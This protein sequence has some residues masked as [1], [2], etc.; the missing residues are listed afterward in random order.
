MAANGESALVP[1]IRFRPRFSLRTVFV[2]F[3]VIAGVL[4]VAN[5]YVR[6]RIERR[7]A[8]GRVFGSGGM[9]W[10][11]NPAEEIGADNPYTTPALNLWGTVDS[12]DIKNDAQAMVVA[13][14]AR[15][16]PE[17]GGIEF[18]RGVT[19]VGVAAIC[20][21]PDCDSIESLSFFDTAVTSEAFSHLGKLPKLQHIMFNTCPINAAGIAE[22]NRVSHLESLIFVEEPARA[23]HDRLDEACFDELGKLFRVQK[24]NLG[25]INVSDIAARKLHGMK[26]LNTLIFH[27][28]RISDAAAAEL[29]TALPATSISVY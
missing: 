1:P 12:I 10:F 2:T 28:G 11:E 20:D 6:P 3:S 24:L 16:I 17:L 9:V 19:N 26:Q 14:E 18:G 4:V 29:R 8:V 13:Q 5:V 21:S 7:I 15:R 27:K 22:L 23:N 25:G